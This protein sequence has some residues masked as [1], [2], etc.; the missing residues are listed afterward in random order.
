LAQPEN[1]EITQMLKSTRTRFIPQG[2]TELV[3]PASDAAAYI[4]RN[5]K[6]APCVVLYAGK[7]TKSAGHYSFRSNEK[8]ESAVIDFFSARRRIVAFRQQQT[9]ER[10]AYKND[11]QVGDVLVCVWGYDQTNVNYYEVTES[12]GQMVTVHAIAQESKATGWASGQ[13]A[14]SPGTF[15]GEPLRR[16]ATLH[17]IKISKGQNARRVEFVEVA[18]VK[19][20]KSRGWTAYA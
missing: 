16:K 14:P 2:S 3:D 11:Y 5:S 8:L 7:A 10:N 17:G 6:G 18:G 1:R 4:Y 12:K 20:Y 13:C 19:V 15:I 9:A